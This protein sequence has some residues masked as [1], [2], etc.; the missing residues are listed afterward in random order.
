MTEFMY[1][2]GEYKKLGESIKKPLKLSKILASV[3]C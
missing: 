3:L 1:E 2:K